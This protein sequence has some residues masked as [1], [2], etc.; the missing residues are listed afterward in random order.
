MSFKVITQTLAADLAASG[1]VTLAYPAGT[2]TGSFLHNARHVMVALGTVYKAP[3]D[4]T[5]TLNTG[6]ITLTLGS[7]KTTIP[8]G[9]DISV[10]LEMFGQDDREPF[11][12]DGVLR[13][14]FAPSVFMDLGAPITADIDALIDA[15]TGAEIPDAAETVSYSFPA[16]NV[17]PQ[18]GVNQSGVLDVPRNI[19]FTVTHASSIVA[20]T[21]LVVGTDEYGIAMSEAFAVTA[22]GTTKT[23]AGKKAFKT[24]TRIDLTAAADASANTVEVGF[25]DVLGLP[26]AL[27][28]TGLVV[29]E[30]ED[31]AAPTA[32]TLVV[33]DFAKPTTSTGDVRGTY[34]PNSACN[35]VKGFALIAALPDP[36]ERGLVQA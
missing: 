29:R 34:D 3:Y 36:T 27:P 17:S 4:F 22:T 30:L 5:I 18:D 32:G 28:G 33:A 14:V 6:D 31:H 35:G 10:Q 20:M 7:G 12:F 21:F 11:K 1:T 19:T 16:S 24:I 23:A 15:A 2:R 8:S 9:T 13:S 26:I 25:G